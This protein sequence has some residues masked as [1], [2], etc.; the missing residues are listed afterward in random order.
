M[1]SFSPTTQP[2]DKEQ[3]RGTLN[4]R[5]AD[6]LLHGIEVYYESHILLSSRLSFCPLS[7]MKLKRAEKECLAV[8]QGHWPPICH[9]SQ[10]SLSSWAEL[11]IRS[12]ATLVC[13]RNVFSAINMYLL[14]ANRFL[15]TYYN[16]LSHVTTYIPY[17]TFIAAVKSYNLCFQPSLRALNQGIA[18][19]KILMGH[20]AT[21]Q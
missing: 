1:S 4:T 12:S 8:L 14:T 5:W 19:A 2:Q 18:T 17:Q 3:M 21:F 6:A 16:I 11:Q 10:A 7:S 20:T 13:L 15:Q 9:F